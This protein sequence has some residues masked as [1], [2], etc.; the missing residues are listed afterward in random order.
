MSDIMLLGILNMPLDYPLDELTHIQLVSA[1][2]EAAARIIKLENVETTNA[3]L[4]ED[5][6]IHKKRIAELEATVEQMKCCNS[7]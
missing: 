6:Q 4:V 3:R 5:I 7:E 2:R 1:C